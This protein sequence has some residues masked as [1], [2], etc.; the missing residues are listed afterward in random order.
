MICHR[1]PNDRITAERQLV[2][3]TGGVTQ[4]LTV[5]T[6]LLEG[7]VASSSNTSLI[8]SLNEVDKAITHH[9]SPPILTKDSCQTQKKTLKRRAAES[10][11]SSESSKHSRTE[12]TVTQ[13]ITQ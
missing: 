9:C 1:T 11:K 7:G 6:S 10:S 13:S 3:L 4:T 2:Q 12:A 8:N 5:A